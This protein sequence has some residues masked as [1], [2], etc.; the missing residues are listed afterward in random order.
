MKYL[1]ILCERIGNYH[2]DN[3]QFGQGLGLF[4]TSIIS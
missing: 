4:L 3:R 2:P 1:A